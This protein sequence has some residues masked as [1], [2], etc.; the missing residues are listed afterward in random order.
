MK[1]FK[2]K[3]TK[4][5]PYFNSEAYADPTAYNGIKNVMKEESELDK[6][7]GDLVHV[8]KV[9]CG[10]AGFEIVGR[11]QFKHKKSGKIFK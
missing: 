8:F 3:K 6:Q 7:V 4:S 2:V 9:I 10:L 5:N 1:L 11:V